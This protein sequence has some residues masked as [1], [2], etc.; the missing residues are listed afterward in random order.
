MQ[1]TNEP[2]IAT[3]VCP[4]C[5][6][7]FLDK[8]EL[9][10][11]ATGMAGDIEFCTLEGETGEDG[12]PVR[13]CPDCGDQ[14]MSK[15]NLLLHSD[16]IFDYC[17]SCGGFFLDKGERAKMNA[18]LKALSGKRGGEES[19]TY[20]GDRLVTIDILDNPCSYAT[21]T[22]MDARPIDAK[23]IC[24]TV[25]F[26]KPLNLGLR[27]TKEKWSFKLLKIF[28]LSGTQDIETGNSTFDSAFLVQ[29]DDEEGLK[30]IL[31]RDAQDAICNFIEKK[32]GIMS[33]FGSLQMVDDC[34]RYTEGPY[35]GALADDLIGRA[36]K[37]AD[38]LLHI[39]DLME[40]AQ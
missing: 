23:L 39:A 12:R 37:V 31:T 38:T 29:A 3:D 8:G 7:I 28:G 30:R 6:G 34:I 5:G 20:H 21:Y 35:T 22:G 36:Q 16:L 18:E 19:R 2:D 15:E 24:V 40:T 10:K 17:P 32:Q 27:L 13:T 1:R 26:S 33:E 11:L 4:S 9:N 14:A 25:Y